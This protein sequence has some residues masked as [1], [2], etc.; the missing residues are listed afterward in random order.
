VSVQLLFNRK[1]RNK[2]TGVHCWLG[3]R[4]MLG[5]V[6]QRPDDGSAVAERRNTVDNSERVDCRL[7]QLPTVDAHL[8]H[9]CG[10]LTQPDGFEE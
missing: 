6:L 10:V 5:A 8:V 3:W 9:G 7:E 4:R 2:S 1:L